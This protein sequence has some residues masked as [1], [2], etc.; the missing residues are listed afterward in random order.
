MT[1]IVLALILSG[2]AGTGVNSPSTVMMLASPQNGSVFV[3]RDTGY[4][5]SAALIS[6]ALNGQSIGNVGNKET[7]IGRST[8]GINFIEAQYSGVQGIGINATNATFQKQ[9]NNNKYFI[10]TTRAGLLQNS[11]QILEV[12]ADSFKASLQ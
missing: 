4:V 11:I 3:L 7:V 2:C 8:S 5:G 6:V 9:S 10:I 12:S 1:L